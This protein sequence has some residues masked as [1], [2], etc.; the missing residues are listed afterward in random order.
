MRNYA[1]HRLAPWLAHVM[2]SRQGTSR[3]LLTPGEVM[4]LPA[5]DALVLLSGTP[6]VRARKQRY[7]EDRRFTA[8]VSPPPA[9]AASG[10]ADRPPERPNDWA[11]LRVAPVRLAV[12]ERE[13]PICRRRDLTRSRRRSGFRSTESQ[14]GS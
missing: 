7:F 3:P 8:R 1:G 5:T 13:W 4:Q 10:F 2:V 12:E 9:L 6:P 11:D 14:S